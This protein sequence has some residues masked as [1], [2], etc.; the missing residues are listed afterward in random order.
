MK[1]KLLVWFLGLV[2]IIASLPPLF[3]LGMG[4]AS[5][6]VEQ[7]EEDDI[8]SFLPFL[9][10]PENGIAPTPTN[11]VMP[12]FPSSTPTGQPPTLTPTGQLPTPTATHTGQP[13]FPTSTPTPGPSPTPPIVPPGMIYIYH[14]SVALFDDIPPEY[15]EA[16]RYLTQ[17]FSDRSVGQNIN[18]SL[19]C[20]T[21]ASWATSPA[22]CRNDYYDSEWNWKTYTQADWDQG[23]VPA[24]ITFYPDPVNY[25]RGN[26]TFEFRG[27]TWS[28]LTQNFIQELAP[29]TWITSPLYQ[30]SY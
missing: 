7:I 19:D 30:F 9:L 23:L 17:L 16:A 15:L 20:L 21:A 12:P 24:R 10:K 27:G 5:D 3:A 4:E 2:L 6:D 29:A 25:N 8:V 22:F 26:W 1:Y 11:P 13:P 14:T 18:E 28:E